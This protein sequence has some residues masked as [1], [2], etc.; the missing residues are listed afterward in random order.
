R[1][2]PNNATMPSLGR[3]FISP[4]GNGS[5]DSG[6]VVTHTGRGRKELASLQA[7]KEWGP[8]ELQPDYPGGEPVAGA[9]PSLELGSY[10]AQRV[11]AFEHQHQNR[12]PDR[13]VGQPLLRSDALA[14]YQRH[15]H[16]QHRLYI[17]EQA[18]QGEVQA[19]GDDHQRQCQ[20]AEGTQPENQQLQPRAVNDVLQGGAIGQGKGGGHRQADDQ[21]QP[22]P[23]KARG[24]HA[25]TQNEVA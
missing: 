7:S 13:A 14:K 12:Q 6:A 11:H 15:D 19:R 22:Q 24:I 16:Q 8:E 2:N 5:A 23:T 18:E 17:A 4:P 9:G 20:G 21:I 10:L 1:Q 3:I 25:A